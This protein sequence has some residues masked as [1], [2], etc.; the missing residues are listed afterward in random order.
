[1]VAGGSGLIG[2]Q[3]VGLLNE[4]GARVH[5]VSLDDDRLAPP[6]CQFLKLDLTEKANCLAACKD[7]EVVFNLLCAKGSPQMSK[8]QPASFFVPIIQLSINLMEAARICGVERYLFASSLAVYPPAEIFHEDDV[9]LGDPSPNDRFA[10]WAKRMGELQAEAYA[11]EYHW[12]G[13]SIVRPANTYG[14]HDD[15]GKQTAM[16]VPSLIRRAL[17]G[18]NPLTVWGDGSAVR[19]FIHARDVARGMMMVVKKGITQPMN[20]GSGSGVSIRDLVDAIIKHLPKTP[21]VIWDATKPGGDPCRVLDTARARSFGI[22]PTISLVTGIAETMDWYQAHANASDL[23]Y[24]VFS[25]GDE[26]PAG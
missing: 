3:L 14:P 5:V 8:I 25:D 4:R 16:V 10:G 2:R 12:R 11:I 22:K 19:D 1:M 15:F 17:S 6:E 18:E 7:I 13:V 26:S 9:W 23:R 21:E 24:N 20:L